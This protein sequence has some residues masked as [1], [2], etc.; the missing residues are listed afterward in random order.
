MT[1][2]QQKWLL[3]TPRLYFDT[4]T[5]INM[6]LEEKPATALQEVS[7]LRQLHCELHP[8]DKLT[9]FVIDGEYLLER[10]GET[11][12]IDDYVPNNEICKKHRT[13][14]IDDFLQITK[15]G[16]YNSTKVQFNFEPPTV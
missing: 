5:G 12:H 14:I 8:Q 11:H 3:S 10:H 4:R 6:M 13:L 1:A 7:L 16:A 2:A 15:I 9:E